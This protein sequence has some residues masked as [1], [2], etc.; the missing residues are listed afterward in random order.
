M[1]LRGEL[2][3]SSL[4]F[5]WRAC[6]PFTTHPTPLSGKFKLGGLYE[7]LEAAGH[8]RKPVD[9]E[10]KLPDNKVLAKVGRA[11]LKLAPNIPSTSFCQHS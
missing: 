6:R 7:L 3:L 8:L 2:S 1:F 11:V 4:F 9:K 5:L 10:T